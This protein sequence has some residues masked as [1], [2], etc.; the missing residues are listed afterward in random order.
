VTPRGT[1]ATPSLGYS[2]QSTD[3]EAQLLG[4]NPMLLHP[5]GWAPDTTQE[6]AAGLRVN[7]LGI[8]GR[9]LPDTRGQ[10]SLLGLQHPAVEGP[11]QPHAKPYKQP[12][13]HTHT[14]THTGALESA[15]VGNPTEHVT[16][17]RIGRWHEG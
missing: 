10:L 7:F 8:L 6:G 4:L 16:W 14:H 9:C 13:T 1:P 2:D 5:R 12:H 17:E 11:C 15:P 3:L